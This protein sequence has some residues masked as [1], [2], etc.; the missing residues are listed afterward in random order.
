MGCFSEAS[1]KFGRNSTTEKSDNYILIGIPIEHISTA[2]DL[3]GDRLVHNVQWAEDLAPEEAQVEWVN[4]CIKGPDAGVPIDAEHPPFGFQRGIPWD[5]NFN[6]YT[7]IK[8]QP[9]LEDN[10]D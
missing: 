7:P 1:M 3:L 9:E 8:E 4:L 10:D 2:E 5:I 6:S